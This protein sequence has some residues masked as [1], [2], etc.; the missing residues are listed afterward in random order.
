M[1]FSEAPFALLR[2]T[3]CDRTVKLTHPEYDSNMKTHEWPFCC[4]EIMSL[5]VSASEPGHDL[6]ARH[7]STSEATQ[8]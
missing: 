8:R 2:C 3:T 6:R 5:V 7:G 1:S 4:D